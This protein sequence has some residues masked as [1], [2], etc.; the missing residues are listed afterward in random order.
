VDGKMKLPDRP[1][2]GVRLNREIEMQRPYPH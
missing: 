1:G 2:F